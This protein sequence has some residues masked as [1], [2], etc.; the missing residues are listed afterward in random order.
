MN[1]LD[2]NDLAVRELVEQ[3]EKE[4]IKEELRNWDTN[5]VYNKDIREKLEDLLKFKYKYEAETKIHTK[6][7]VTEL[8]RLSQL[9]EEDSGF[10]LKLSGQRSDDLRV[11][12]FISNGNL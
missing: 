1:I 12:N 3:I 2:F 7:T 5:H 9:E 4:E 8:K 6:L 11:P 10:R